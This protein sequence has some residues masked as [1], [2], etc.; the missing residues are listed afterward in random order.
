MISRA[1]FGRAGSAAFG[2]LSLTVP[3]R[4]LLWP[5]AALLPARI[6]EEVPVLSEDPD[7]TLHPPRLVPLNAQDEAEAVRLLARLLANAAARQEGRQ[8]ARPAGQLIRLHPNTTRRRK[9]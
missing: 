3:S 9:R 1:L 5:G 7:F 4:L 2:R 8:R 6:P